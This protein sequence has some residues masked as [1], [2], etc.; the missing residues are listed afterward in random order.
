MCSSHSIHIRA[1]SAGGRFLAYLLQCNE[2]AALAL[3]VAM[4]WHPLG[5]AIGDVSNLDRLSARLRSGLTEGSELV[6]AETLAG[7]FIRH[8]RVGA[9]AAE[10]GA[11]ETRLLLVDYWLQFPDLRGLCLLGF[12]SPHVFIEPQ[13]LLLLDNIVLT[14]A[15]A[16]ETAGNTPPPSA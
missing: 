13:L 4:C 10:L 7:P 11:S 14:G 15:R 3:N 12:S 2:R 5:P 1:T 6:G 9:G 16:L 8:S